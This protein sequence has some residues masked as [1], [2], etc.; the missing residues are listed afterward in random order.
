MKQ[1]KGRM[2]GYDVGIFFDRPRL[3]EE[4]GRGEEKEASREESEKGDIERSRNELWSPPVLSGQSANV[5]HR[6]RRIAGALWTSDN[7]KE[8][9][10][11][12]FQVLLLSA[13]QVVLV[14][15][16]QVFVA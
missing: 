4:G 15:A 5:P 11:D 3:R 2:V 16:L 13:K 9:L 1:W 12:I 7:L 8:D 6:S 10:L 14:Q